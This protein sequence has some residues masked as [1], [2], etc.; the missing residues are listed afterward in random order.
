M[1]GY[2]NSGCFV[3]YC[4]GNWVCWVSSKVGSFTKIR[5]SSKIIRIYL[6]G[7]LTKIPLKWGVKQLT[8]VRNKEVTVQPFNLCHKMGPI[9]DTGSVPK[10][11]TG[12]GNLCA[13][14]LH[15]SPIFHMAGHFTKKVLLLHDIWLLQCTSWNL[16]YQRI[17]YFPPPLA[18]VKF[19]VK[20]S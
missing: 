11:V 9:F 3:C 18:F 20:N 16:V 14:T 7:K 1:S 15:L 12:I 5:T 17:D 6:V 2:S 13:K 8:R 19:G 4:Q 10:T